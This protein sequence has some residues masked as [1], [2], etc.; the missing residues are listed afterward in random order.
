ME[1]FDWPNADHMRA[2]RSPPRHAITQTLLQ[3]LVPTRPTATYL[4]A[5]IMSQR[6]LRLPIRSLSSTPSRNGAQWVCRRCLATTAASNESPMSPSAVLQ[7]KS[8]ATAEAYDPTLPTSQRDY[9]LKKSDFYLKKP[10]P[11]RIPFQYLVNS[12]SPIL[13]KEERLAREQAKLAHKPKRLVGVVVSSGKMDKTVKV[14]LPG[15]RWNK[16]IHKVKRRG[17]II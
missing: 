16:K 6:T 14:R 17:E 1:P 7:K 9:R 8:P 13:P 4:I 11:Q 12:T 3:L 2:W 15:Q 10:I 5:S